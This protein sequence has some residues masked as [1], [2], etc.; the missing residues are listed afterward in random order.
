MLIDTRLTPINVLFHACFLKQIEPFFATY[1]S[2]SLFG[3]L[4]YKACVK[5]I[6]VL[7]FI[8]IFHLYI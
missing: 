2:S 5:F 6:V 7:A 8:V 3:I 4:V 1:L